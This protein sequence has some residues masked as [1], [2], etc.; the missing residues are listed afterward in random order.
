MTQILVLSPSLFPDAYLE[1]NLNSWRQGGRITELRGHHSVE[2]RPS[3][4]VYSPLNACGSLWYSFA[5]ISFLMTL[6]I[7]PAS[8]SAMFFF[9]SCSFLS[10]AAICLEKSKLF[11]CPFCCSW[12]SLSL[13]SVIF[14]SLPQRVCW[15]MAISFSLAVKIQI[16]IKDTWNKD[17]WN[18]SFESV[19]QIGNY[20]TKKLN[21]LWRNN[22]RGEGR[23]C[24][25]LVVMDIQLNFGHSTV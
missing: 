2:T 19:G 16:N 22:E 23:G 24:E 14:L 9:A 21:C 4:V 1:H 10:I 6:K 11:L 8:S 20:K 18:Y 17:E 7:M 5:S 25:G 3:R 12:Y 13:R 15:R